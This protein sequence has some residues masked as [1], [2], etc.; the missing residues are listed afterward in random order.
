MLP[1]LRGQVRWFLKNEAYD[2]LGVAP[3][4]V[5]IGQVIGHLY[6]YYHT[7]TISRG[8]LIKYTAV[9][10]LSGG[11]SVG[12][13]LAA[14]I[15]GAAVGSLLLPGVGTIIGVCSSSSVTKY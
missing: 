12:I 4:A 14:T 11:S 13:G 5:W 2:V 8:Q 7:H 3:L 1:L 10:G 9:D 15:G 6:S